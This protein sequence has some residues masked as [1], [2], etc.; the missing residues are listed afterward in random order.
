MQNTTNMLSKYIARAA[1][2][3]AYLTPA[4]QSV[5]HWLESSGQL[6]LEMHANCEQ[7]FQRME[8]ICLVIT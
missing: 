6:C 4:L 1:K 2:K 3:H 7:A 8:L 5:Y